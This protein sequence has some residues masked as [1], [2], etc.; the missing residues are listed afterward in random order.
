MWLIAFA[1]VYV[2][3]GVWTAGREYRLAMADCSCHEEELRAALLGLFFPLTWAY[4]TILRGPTRWVVALF[5]LGY[6]QVDKRL[7]LPEARVVERD[8]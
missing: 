4:R 7:S 1:P 6:R 5:N 8:S 2:L 3:L